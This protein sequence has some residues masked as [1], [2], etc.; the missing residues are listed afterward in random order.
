MAPAFKG[1]IH[2]SRSI[3]LAYVRVTY[4]V[5]WNMV[6]YGVRFDTAG[7]HLDSNELKSFRETGRAIEPV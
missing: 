5:R 1:E 6:E 2:A 3:R 4:R 7:R